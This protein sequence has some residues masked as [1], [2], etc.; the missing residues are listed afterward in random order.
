MTAPADR[1]LYWHRELPPLDADIMGEHVVEAASARVSG[2][3]A[4]RDELWDQCYADLMARTTSR[5]E[6]EVA[7]LGGH[8]A[9][10]LDE[11][12]DAHHDDAAVEAWLTGRF[13]YVLYRRAGSPTATTPE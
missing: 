5:I 13:R 12:I 9:H 2:T 4:H 11:E 10:V 6:Q 8:Y 1:V 7:R 3:L